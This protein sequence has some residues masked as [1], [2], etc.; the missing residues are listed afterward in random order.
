MPSLTLDKDFVDAVN[1]VIRL[2][3]I[4]LMWLVPP[5]KS[6]SLGQGY[7]LPS[8]QKM[9]VA[10]FATYSYKN[11]DGQVRS[12]DQAVGENIYYAKAVLIDPREYLRLP[13]HLAEMARVD[14]FA[15]MCGMTREEERMPMQDTM[16][17]RGLSPIP[18]IEPV[19]IEGV[20]LFQATWHGR[21]RWWPGFNAER[22]EQQMY[23]QLENAFF[24]DGSIQRYSG[25]LRSGEYWNW[26]LKFDAIK[27]KVYY[28]P[29]V[30][31]RSSDD[32]EAIL[33]GLSTGKI[34][35]EPLVMPAASVPKPPIPQAEPKPTSSVPSY[36]PKIP[37]AKQ[38]KKTFPKRNSVKP[39][40]KLKNK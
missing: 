32:V 18:A 35:D 8:D 40:S 33:R 39:V 34:K 25:G 14:K 24:A 22:W 28:D 20:K 10:G 23:P 5:L 16:P 26:P 37:V 6:L 15:A 9:R 21:D 13:S 31:P 38:A 3:G 36:A 29:K 17:R 12:E 30:N 2:H 4:K 27:G 7:R 1:E 19:I 11:W